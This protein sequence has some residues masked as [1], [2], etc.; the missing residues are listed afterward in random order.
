ML[1]WSGY[2]AV[3]EKDGATMFGLF[4]KKRK[5]VLPQTAYWSDDPFTAFRSLH[6][7]AA[8]EILD[9]WNDDDRDAGTLMAVTLHIGGTI[10]A[11]RKHFPNRTPPVEDDSLFVR[12]TTV[13]SGKGNGAK[14]PLVSPLVANLKKYHAESDVSLFP[15]IM[16][17]YAP[18]AM[19]KM[20]V[21]MFANPPKGIVTLPWGE[22][23]ASAVR[24]FS[25]CC[26]GGPP[27]VHRH[28]PKCAVRL[29]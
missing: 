26:D 8:H 25:G 17:T 3:A 10:A 20:F 9:A 13:G 23:E 4:K 27:C 14:F 7:L 24:K 29:G 15:L 16:G 6:I 11:G 1:G 19:R 5:H 12:L 2:K 18:T 28:S 21:E 22:R